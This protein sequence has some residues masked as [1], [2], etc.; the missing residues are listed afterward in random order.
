MSVLI[1]TCGIGILSYTPIVNP[2]E[3]SWHLRH[4]HICHLSYI[5]PLRRKPVLQHE[6]ILVICDERID[7]IHSSVSDC[8][9]NKIPRV[10]F[11]SCG[12][13]EWVKHLLL[14]R[15]LCKGSSAV[16]PDAAGN[17]NRSSLQLHPEETNKQ[18]FKIIIRL[19]HCFV[20]IIVHKYSRI[21]AVI[22]FILP[23]EE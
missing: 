13:A 22:S 9:I 10:H 19:F 23:L 11:V 7:T 5:I 6:P 1:W 21:K 17:A 2:Q 20:H 14:L 4:C 16:S 8:G 15:P 12:L 18:D 3:N